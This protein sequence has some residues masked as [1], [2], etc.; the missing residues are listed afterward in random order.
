[1]REYN[2]E[3][4]ISISYVGGRTRTQQKN[5]TSKL[6]VLQRK[7][8]SRPSKKTLFQNGAR[9][10]QCNGI[11]RNGL[12]NE[13]RPKLKQKANTNAKGVSISKKGIIIKIYYI[14]IIIIVI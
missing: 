10:R 12:K 3:L 8:K 14:L 9:P 1:M 11:N 13:Q 6:T 7:R 4:K 5:K 2:K